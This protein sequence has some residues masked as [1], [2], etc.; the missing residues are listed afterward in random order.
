[1][2][3]IIQTIIPVLSTLAGIWLGSILTR[4]KEDRQWR[5][6][7]CLEAYTDVMRGCE[8]IT[9]EAT[10]LYLELCDPTTQLE[11][12]FEKALELHRATQRIMLLAPQM[13]PTLTALVV[14]CEKQ[15]VTRAGASPKPPLDE[16]RKI[17]TTD[18][19][20]VVG[21]FTNEARNDL[22]VHSPRHIGGQWRK[23][24]A[25]EARQSVDGRRDPAQAN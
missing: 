10:K 20:V 16:W 18:L 8:V 9:N 7:R 22:G 3:S 5:R 6:D 24:F 2:A 4:S 17:T 25:D 11:L 19:A 21:Q 1:M 13:M 15:I 12:L 14:H 23:M